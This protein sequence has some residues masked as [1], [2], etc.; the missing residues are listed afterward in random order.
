MKQ[1]NKEQLEALQAEHGDEFIE[2]MNAIES[3]LIRLLEIG[4]KIGSEVMV[5]QKSDLC[6]IV[7]DE[8]PKIKDNAS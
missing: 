6:L 7:S 3:K 4:K 8:L 5:I 2:I 1:L